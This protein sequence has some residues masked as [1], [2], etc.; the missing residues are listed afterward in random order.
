MALNKGLYKF[1]GYSALVM[2]AAFVVVS[3][4]LYMSGGNYFASVVVSTIEATAGV[5]LI[6]KSQ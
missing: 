2:S 6:K 1:L 5:Y 3:F 4:M